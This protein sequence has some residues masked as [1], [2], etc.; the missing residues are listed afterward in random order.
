VA[1]NCGF[2][3]KKTEDMYEIYE[4]MFDKEEES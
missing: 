3:W 4:Y 1:D 2:V